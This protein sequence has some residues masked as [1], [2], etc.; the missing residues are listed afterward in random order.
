M[1]NKLFAVP[2]EALKIDEANHEFILNVDKE[3]LQRAPGFDKDDWPDMA[4]PTWGDQVHDHYGYTPY[5]KSGAPGEV[6][7]GRV[8]EPQEAYQ[9]TT[10]SHRERRDD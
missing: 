10:S 6:E 5:W 8:E 3:F 1:G 2:W 4:D 9:G 7:R